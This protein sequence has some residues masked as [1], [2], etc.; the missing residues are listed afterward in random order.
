MPV[1]FLAACIA[2]SGIQVITFKRVALATAPAL[3]WL[4]YNFSISLAG[5]P[6][7]LNMHRFMSLLI[8]LY[9]LVLP[10]LLTCILLR[11]TREVE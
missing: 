8:M 9:T 5:D 6:D 1:L 3:V 7:S 11:W 10:Y 2:T 4:G